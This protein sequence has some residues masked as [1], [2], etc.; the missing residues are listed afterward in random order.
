[1]LIKSLHDFHDH[2]YVLTMARNKERRESIK[3]VLDG[4]DLEFFVGR[5]K[6][7][8]AKEEL[9]K[10]GVYDENLAK[11]L[12]RRNKPM[13]TGHICCSWGHRLIYEDMIEK[14]HEKVLVFED[15]VL[16]NKEGNFSIDK[17]LANVPKDAELI[18]WGWLAIENRPKFAF[19]KEA[20]YHAQH[21]LGMLRYNH[22]MIKNLYPRPYNQYFKIAGKTFCT[23]AYTVTKAAAEKLIKR[24]TPIVFNADN[25]LMH[26]VLNGNLK[27]YI[28]TPQIF[29]QGSID[30]NPNFKSLTET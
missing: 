9:I 19:L 8:F 5:D 1:M 7:D 25:L 21:S 12:D 3:S 6:A 14:G 4:W 2:R 17:I 29:S 24:Q 16:P 22:N 11:K 28:A 26:E 18:Y 30:D 20:V 10:S 27:A 23:H 13:K 15:D